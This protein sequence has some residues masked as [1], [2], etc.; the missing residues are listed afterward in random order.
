VTINLVTGLVLIMVLENIMR[1]KGV[2]A[3]FVTLL[4][5]TKSIVFGA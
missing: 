5:I 3:L 1:K 4:P 2:L